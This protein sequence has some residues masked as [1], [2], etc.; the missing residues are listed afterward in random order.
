VNSFAK[1]E[2]L[3][4]D[5]NPYE[6]FIKYIKKPL[7]ILRI[8]ALMFSIIVFGCV[9][10]Q[11]WRWDKHTVSEVCIIHDSYST[12]RLGSTVA[13]LAF[14]LSIGILVCEF[15]F[16]QLPTTANRKQ[17][18]VVDLVFSGLFSIL[19]LV[20][21]SSLAHQWSLSKE[22]RGHYGRSN[23]GAAIAFSFFSIFIWSLH[24][25]AAFRRLQVGVESDVEESLLPGPGASVR[26]GYTEFGARG[27]GAYQDIGGYTRG[28]GPQHTGTLKEPQARQ[29]KPET[30]RGPFSQSPE[31]ARS[32]F[33][34]GQETMSRPDQVLPPFSVHNTEPPASQ[35]LGSEGSSYQELIRY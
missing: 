26:S 28:Q 13:I 11:G 30:T 27:V 15:Y 31:V 4:P 29:Y 3:D 16:E 21:F 14:I 25:A 12:C 18:V 24:C 32:P 19:F 33:S 35:S 22:P 5:S 34:R 9:T 20:S 8:F 23:I 2:H 1:M 17:V 6:H 10:S 7:V